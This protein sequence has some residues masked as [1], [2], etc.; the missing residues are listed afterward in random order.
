LAPTFD[1]KAGNAT[2]LVDGWVWVNLTNGTQAYLTPDLTTFSSTPA[3]TVTDFTVADLS[4][5]LLAI[6]IPGNL[7]AGQYTLLAAGVIPA[8]NPWDPA[9][10]ATNLATA[11]VTLVHRDI[12]GPHTV[13]LSWLPPTTNADGSAAVDLAGYRIYLGTTTDCYLAV[14][15]V[16]SPGVTSYVIENLAQNTYYFTLTAYTY[17]GVESQPSD[18]VGIVLGTP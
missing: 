15:D 5:T 11:E 18:V 17:M 6:P 16:P 14:I 8:S 3:P 7:A 12:R 10:Y 2:R 4:K 1:L 13:T 9:N